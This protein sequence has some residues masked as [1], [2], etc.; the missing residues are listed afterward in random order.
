MVRGG[1]GSEEN[2]KETSIQLD[3]SAE[4]RLIKFNNDGVTRN[5]LISEEL[6]N[7]K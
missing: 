7:E 2:R 3:W 6:L 4:K 5:N 1:F